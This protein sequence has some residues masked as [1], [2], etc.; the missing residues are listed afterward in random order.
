MP[1]QQSAH[2]L[3]A[4]F[5]PRSVAVLGASSRPGRPGYQ[6][7]EVLRLL[8]DRLA[9]HPI[10]PRYDEVLGLPCFDRI[11]DAPATDLA[12]VASGPDRIES[13]V[14]DAIAHG[15]KGLLVLGAPTA[16]ASRPAWLGRIA[17]MTA[18][19]GVPLVGP[20]SL[21]FVN[22]AERCGATWAVPDQVD[23]GGIA[24]VSQSGTVFW[25]AI[26]NDPRLRFSFSGHSGLE[27]TLTMADLVSYSLSLESTRVVGIYVETIR[28]AQGFALALEEAAERD[29]PVVAMYAGRTQKARAQMM[30]HA[31]RLAG[32][33]S[34]LE[35]VFRRYGVA[36]AET[37]DEWWT[38]LALL[39]A[40]RRVASGGI[41]AV[42]DS[43][44]GLAMFLDYTSE[45]GIPIANLSE[46]T[47]RRAAA[48]LGYDGDIEGA[49]DF[50]IGDADRH[51]R[52][53]DLLGVLVEDEDAAAVMAFTTYAE[54][55]T[56]GFARNIA[57]ACM[58][59][60]TRTDKPVIAA[61]YTSRQ[62]YPDLMMEIADAGLP[63][64]DG[65][66]TA[67]LAVR[68]AFAHRSFREL[69]AE[70]RAAVGAQVDLDAA[71]AAKW[72]QR[73]V[74]TSELAEADALAM[75]SDFGV[76]CVRTERADSQADA[77]KAAV[78]VGFPV[79]L[80]TD[81]GIAHKA[82]QG[83]VRL[84]L[85]DERAVREA[86]AEM[87]G[88]LG[89]RVVV[90]P[91]AAGLEI[92]IGMV[93]GQFGPTIMVGAGGT[94]IEVLADRCHLLAP[95]SSEEARL[96]LVDLQLSRVIRAQFGEGSLA[97]RSLADV[98]ARVSRI[99]A[100][101]DGVIAE[102]DINPVLLGVDGCIAVDALVGVSS[103]VVQSQ[104]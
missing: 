59:V 98:V 52:T 42:M 66:R 65:M 88:V 97:E 15:V 22:Y 28:D 103:G 11:A 76:P 26:T 56:A 47:R 78:A 90:A 104:Q 67:L 55:S 6:V 51:S 35:A 48:M 46:R 41:S 62:L 12:I 3:A 89:P 43:G 100:E 1:D 36:R 60:S 4:L 18:H 23:P 24:I 33:H 34:A 87:A 53:E 61:T 7:L 29:I 49:L 94:L 73:L 54:A 71:V 81:E 10:T 69:R 101:F 85:A 14:A 27:S 95:V 72:R 32:D 102:L 17:E 84:S 50:W 68:H 99:A 2:P 63:I 93:A 20:D 9:V 80:K 44:G 57:E 86:Y 70:G 79:V 92:A 16:G 77:V 19:A 64:L 38:T 13:E 58:S 21:G 96:A 45:L 75:L 25:E 5:A 37:P 83:G 31:G 30:T 39:G 82:A 40:P 91:M 74:G 8:D